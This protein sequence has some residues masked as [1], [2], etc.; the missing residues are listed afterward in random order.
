MAEGERKGV[1][2]PKPRSLLEAMRAAAWVRE[3]MHKTGAT[4]TGLRDC[5]M[6]AESTS[7]ARFDRYLRGIKVPSP[8]IREEV[9]RDPKLAYTRQVYDFGP[10]EDGV[11][12]PLWMLFED[13][14]DEF[15]PVIESVIGEGTDR[16]EAVDKLA[17]LF[18]PA[19]QWREI[20]DKNLRLYDAG[21]LILST[22]NAEGA[23]P[24]L[25]TLA[26]V[27]ALWRLCLRDGRDVAPMEYL[28]HALL[29]GP[30]RGVLDA[31]S[32]YEPFC[33]YVHAFAVEHY[34]Q[35]GQLD[36]AM[37]AFAGLLPEN[38]PGN[39]RAKPAA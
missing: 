9:Y 39:V 5:V 10:S 1:G 35:R 15:W 20:R 28:L 26:A 18:M 21:S 31:L 27:F 23:T 7:G 12:V 3:L 24:K 13:R 19:N 4:P 14:H 38:K 16:A 34:M 6:P 36:T 8:E 11:C 25:R 32:I 37:S 17:S 22:L 2:G 29:A 33:L 30:Y